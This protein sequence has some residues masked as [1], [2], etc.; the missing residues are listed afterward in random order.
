MLDLQAIVSWHTTVDR[1]LNVKSVL[2]IRLPTVP[3]LF[4]RLLLFFN[5]CKV[6]LQHVVAPDSILFM[7]SF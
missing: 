3:D 6:L 1:K 7:S 2:S 5:H 4:K